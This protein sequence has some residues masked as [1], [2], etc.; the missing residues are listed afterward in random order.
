MSTVQHVTCTYEELE[1]YL[2]RMAAPADVH[3]P[4]LA[5]LWCAP[6]PGDELGPSS[7]ASPADRPATGLVREVLDWLARHD[8]ARR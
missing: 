1:D 4:D 2:T 8:L 6:E 5:I 3:D 7:S